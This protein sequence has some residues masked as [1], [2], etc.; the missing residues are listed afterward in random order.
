MTR[1]ATMADRLIHEAIYNFLTHDEETAIYT[2]EVNMESNAKDAWE[3]IQDSCVQDDIDA[4]EVE[5][6]WEGLKNINWDDITCSIE[7]YIQNQRE[8]RKEE[9]ED[10]SDSDATPSN[11][12]DS[13]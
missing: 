2:W 11:I 12:S 10:S 3:Y 6:R 5:I 8:L 7:V 1:F 4:A 9:D 13:D